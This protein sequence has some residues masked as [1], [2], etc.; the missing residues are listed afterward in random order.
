[1]STTVVIGGSP[2]GDGHSA[3]LVYEAG[4]NHLGDTALAKK[5][6]DVAIAAGWNSVKFQTRTVDIVYSKD[7]LA[8]PRESPF[9]DT[10]EALKR[11]LEFSKEQYDE[12]NDYCRQ[13]NFTWFSSCWNEEAV[14]LI[15]QYNPPCFKIA[16]ACLTDDNLL[17]HHRQYKKPIILSTAMSTLRQID[18]AV[19]ILGTEDLV[20]MHC[21]GV[22]PAKSEQLNL[23]VI[24]TLKSRYNV[25]VGWSGHELGLATT[26]ASVAMGANIIERHGTLDRSMYGSDQ[27]A[28]VEP[29]GMARISRDIREVEKAMG[30][31]VKRV[32]PEEH[33]IISK[34]RRVDTM[35]L[36]G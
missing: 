5:M 2:V 19:E 31:G 18:R 9:G 22:Y 36:E 23:R 11:G 30:D 35:K 13:R 28:S 17:R 34:L 7:E 6:I 10:N 29:Q 14:D 4:I 1:M 3:V 15:A 12:L 24:E 26:V 16:S 8:K 21:V 33:P 20:L 25:P 27:A 32:Q